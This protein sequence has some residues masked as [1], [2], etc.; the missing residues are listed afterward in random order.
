MHTKQ[1]EIQFVITA[2]TRELAMQIHDKAKQMIQLAGKTH[3]WS[4]KLVIGG[5]DRQKMMHKLKNP[6]HMIIGTP[7]RL[8]DLV[9]EG[10]IS[11]FSAT[12]F[13]IDEADLMADLGL[14]NEIDQ[15]LVRSHPD[16]Q[17]LAFS[18]TIPQQLEHFYKKYLSEPIH[19]KLDDNVLPE[20]MEH[21]LI[22][23][24]HRPISTIVT[25]ISKAINPYLALVFT[26]GKKQADELAAKLTQNGLK[27][28][29][30]HG[31][32]KPRER[33][34][35]L[36]DIQNLRFQYVVATDLA[37]RGIDI[38]G[39]SHVIN[40]QM[41]MKEDFYIHRVGRTA[42]AGMKGTAISLYDETE[43]KRLIEKL[44]QK[45]LTFQF[46]DVKNG[47]WKVIRSPKRRKY[48]AQNRH[49]E[50]RKRVRKRKAIKI[51]PGYKKK[52]NR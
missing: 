34:R 42:R 48:M 32:L 7:G 39:V 51:K 17:I 3:Q 31:G 23:R 15:L 9:K 24:R 49:Q 52:M 33:K 26:N 41:P 47:E 27:T 45:G 35:T 36:K 4:V 1:Q 37:A 22:P 2:P 43:D 6:P 40:A 46:Y 10:V 44:E 12:A 19:F 8:L 21:K 20:T 16:I 14:I 28:G 29:L 25:Q 30:L 13:V 5:M 38:E 18:A 11:I 50:A